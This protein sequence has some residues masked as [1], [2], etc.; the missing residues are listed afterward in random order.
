MILVMVYQLSKHVVF[1]ATKIPCSAE[2]VVKL[3]FKNIAKYWGL[4]LNIVSDRDSRFMSK[5]WTTLFKILPMKL[6]TSTTYHSMTYDK[7]ECI[8]ALIDDYL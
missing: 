3:F 5:F 2:E 4:P 6:L 1:V 8:N 7:I